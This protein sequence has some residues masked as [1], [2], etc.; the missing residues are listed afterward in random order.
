MRR[1]PLILVFSAAA[2]IGIALWLFADDEFSW[3]ST[4]PT[5][6]TIPS[7]EI[8]HQDSA[9]VETDASPAIGV[10]QQSLTFSRRSESCVLDETSIENASSS[11]VANVESRPES[12]L[13]VA[14]RRRNPK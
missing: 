7:G 10:G 8:E 12:A 14:G 9:I 3:P 4:R 13:N 11:P 2:T 6:A 1:P 5:N